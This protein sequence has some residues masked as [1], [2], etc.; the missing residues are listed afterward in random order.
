MHQDDAFFPI[1]LDRA[2]MTEPL[3]KRVADLVEAN[4]VDPR[5]AVLADFFNDDHSFYF[6]LLATPTGHVFQFGYDFLHLAPTEGRLSEWNELTSSWQ[7][8][9]YSEQVEPALEMA[10]RAT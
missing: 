3:L 5:T 9:P 7:D 4:G 6:G 2:A 10:Q 8:S 1:L